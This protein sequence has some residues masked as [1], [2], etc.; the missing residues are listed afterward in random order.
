MS[1]EA[2]MSLREGANILNVIRKKC[3]GREGKKK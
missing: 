1:A 2:R 3:G